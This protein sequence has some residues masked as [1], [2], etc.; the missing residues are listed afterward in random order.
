VAVGIAGYGLQYYG[1]GVFEECGTSLDH[2]VMVVGFRSGTGWRIK[3]SWGKDWGEEGYGWIA[4]GN[5]C[6]IC[7]MAFSIRV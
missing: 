6:G 5:T 2:A 1:S 4:E 7:N 3:N